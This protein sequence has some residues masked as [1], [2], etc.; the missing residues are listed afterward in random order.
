MVTLTKFFPLVQA[1]REQ[2]GVTHV[3]VTNIKEYFSPAVRI[4]FGL[5]KEKKEGHRVPVEWSSNT[6]PFSKLAG[7]RSA[8]PRPEVTPD[9]LAV[10]Q[11]TG[12]TTGTAKGA[13]LSHRNLVANAIQSRTW[14]THSVDGRDVILTV[15][16]LFHVYALTVAMN[17]GLYAGALLVLLPRYDQHEVLEAIKKYRPTVLPGVPT[18]YGGILN[19]P[20][21]AK[22]DLS[23]IRSCISGSAPLPRSLQERF[24]FGHR[25]QA[26]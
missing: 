12:G 21:I 2:A 13:M 7:D 15:L 4:A 10:L 8:R 9:D 26:R 20:D 5:A 14:D 11:Y 23:S 24:E 3:V 17:R 25:R 1:V 22:Y 6:H 18:L 19:A 16:P